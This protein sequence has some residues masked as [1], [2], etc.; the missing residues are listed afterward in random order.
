MTDYTESLFDD[1][2]D[3]KKYMADYIREIYGFYGYGIWTVISKETNEIIGRA[4]V[5][6][7]EGYSYPEIGYVID[8]DYN[9]KKRIHFP[10]PIIKSSSRYARIFC[11]A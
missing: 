4:G 11:A 7:R 8:R 2:E 10:F 1:P 6:M 5:T 9:R 3:E